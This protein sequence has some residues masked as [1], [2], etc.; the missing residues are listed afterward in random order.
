[1]INK[2]AVYMTVA[3][4]SPSVL[5]LRSTLALS[6]YLAQTLNLARTSTILQL[7]ILS[8]IR[9]CLILY[10][11]GHHRPTELQEHPRSEGSKHCYRNCSYK[12]IFCLPVFFLFILASINKVITEHRQI[13]VVC[14]YILFAICKK[15]E[16]PTEHGHNL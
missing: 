11:I 16:L 9:K 1:M 10:G 8:I 3:A 4:L 12:H 5:S 14:M 6:L 15:Y 13:N 7:R 2:D